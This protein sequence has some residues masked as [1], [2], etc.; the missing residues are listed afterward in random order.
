M[1]MDTVDE[2]P[3]GVDWT[4]RPINL[5]GDVLDDSGKPMTEQLELWYHDPV[6][7]VRELM[8]NPMFR[9]VMR[10]A[11]ERVFSD[12]AGNE[13]VINEMWTA[14]WWWDIQVSDG[15]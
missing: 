1:L 7:V 5:N 14:E 10:Y 6:K 12:A 11:P 4:Y 9:D 15:S 8:G 13:E 3:Q 2:L